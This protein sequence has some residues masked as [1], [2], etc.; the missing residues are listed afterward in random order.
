MHE[1]KKIGT[2]IIKKAGE[3]ICEAKKEERARK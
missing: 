2:A 3:N 1:R